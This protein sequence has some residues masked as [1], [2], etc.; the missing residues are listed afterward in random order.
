MLPARNLDDQ[1][2]EEI[3]AHARRLIPR[4]LPEWT[5]ENASDPG[6]TLLELL[7]FLKEMQQYHLNRVP[8]RNILK[9]LKLVGAAPLPARPARAG[10]WVEGVPDD[11]VLL[12]L[13][14]GTPLRADGVR[15]ETACGE[16]LVPAR[17]L[18]LESAGEESRAVTSRSGAVLEVFG[19]QARPGAQFTILFDRPLPHGCDIS[20]SLRL[21][22]GT[23][24]RVPVADGFVPLCRLAWDYSAPEGFAPLTVV[25]DETH[26]FLQ[27]GVLKIRLPGPMT[28]ADGAEGGACRLRCTLMES[29]YDRPPRLEMLRMNVVQAEQRQ[30]I[31]QTLA[32]PP[33]D[34]SGACALPHHL[35]LH[36]H[37]AVFLPRSTGHARVPLR[38]QDNPAGVL[39]RR[40]RESAALV[41]DAACAHRPEPGQAV[42]AVVSDRPFEE[43]FLMH[44]TYLPGQQ[45]ELPVHS[46]VLPGLMLMERGGD[47]VYRDVL[48][49]RDFDDAGPQERRT[50]VRE[51]ERV[52]ATFGDG[53]HGRPPTGDVYVA[54]LKV[55]LGD[56]GNVQ[57]GEIDAFDLPGCELL[58]HNEEHAF[59]GAAAQSVQQAIAAFHREL[60]QVTRAVTLKDFEHIVL[61]TPGLVLRRVHALAG[62]PPGGQTTVNEDNAVTLIVEPDNEAGNRELNR[63][64]RQNILNRANAHRL[65]GTRVFVAPPE[66]ASIDVQCEARMRPGYLEPQRMVESA[67]RAFFAGEWPLGKTVRYAD[68]YG[69]IDTLGCVQQV[70]SLTIGVSGRGATTDAS[71]DVYLPPHGVA[72][73]R[74]VDIAAAAG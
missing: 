54:N 13:P 10:V 69:L 71:G 43:L 28:A 34:E 50:V 30:T 38:D 2:F 11:A 29:Y 16:T 73:L 22:A 23:P 33:P 4:L 25:E 5:D 14:A 35:A 49:G 7:A 68:L 19:A 64:Q 39:L 3:V 66:Y 55:T 74:S 9:F 56:M 31:A 51:G 26:G 58:P 72:V 40:D 47:G 61:G 65:I 70:R 36:G 27:S 67:V 6:I 18:R 21:Q 53:L 1:R 42:R 8:E 59:G 46:A 48:C 17:I 41:F 62:P 57:A 37:V 60:R 45:A 52:V 15:F 20:M 32:L 63:A 12:A 24:P 44:G